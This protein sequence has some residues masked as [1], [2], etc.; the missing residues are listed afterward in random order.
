LEAI[1][2][3]LVI[4]IPDNLSGNFFKVNNI[5]KMFLQLMTP[6]PRGLPEKFPT[7]PTLVLPFSKAQN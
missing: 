5:Q 1:G 4:N 3:K 6:G 7:H 2:P